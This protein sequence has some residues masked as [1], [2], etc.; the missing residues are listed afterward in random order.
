M[1][2]GQNGVVFSLVEPGQNRFNRA[3]SWFLRSN[4]RFPVFGLFFKNSGFFREP[5]RIQYRFTVDP[6]KLAGPVRFLKPWFQKLI[7][8]MKTEIKGLDSE[9]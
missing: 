9:I 3:G 2:S 7:A 5:D 1:E 6:V 8:I 4:R